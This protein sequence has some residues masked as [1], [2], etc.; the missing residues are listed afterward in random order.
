MK[1]K[2]ELRKKLIVPLEQSAKGANGRQSDPTLISCECTGLPVSC[3]L[4]CADSASWPDIKINK[5][6]LS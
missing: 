4:D 5:G 1:K 3:Y 2:L 6:K